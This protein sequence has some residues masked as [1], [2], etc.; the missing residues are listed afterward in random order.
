MNQRRRGPSDLDETTPFRVG[1][2]SIFPAEGR[3]DGPAGTEQVDPKVMAVMVELAAGAGSVVARDNLLE[4]VWKSS[5]VGDDVI[6]RCIYCLRGHLEAASGNPAY[7]EAIKTLPRRGYRLELK[8]IP[9]LEPV[10]EP[11][12]QEGS[13]AHSR[14][15]LLLAALL[16][17]VLLLW[18]RDPLSL[19][20]APALSTPAPS[21]AVLPFA[22]LSA[23]GTQRHL[24][25]GIA[26]GMISK[27]ASKLEIRIIARSSSFALGD[28]ALEADQIASRLGVTHFIEGSVLPDGERIRV[29][30]RL[31][32]AETAS[33]LWSGRWHIA[34]TDLDTV[35]ADLA[36][37]VAGE[38]ALDVRQSRTTPTRPESA[39]ALVDYLLADLLIHRRLSGDLEKALSML[40]KILNAEPAFA[41]GWATLASARWLSAMTAA[42]ENDDVSEEELASGIDAARRAAE[43]AISL[44]PQ[45]VEALL[46][47][48]NVSRIHGQ[49]DFA[50]E[51]FER[52]ALIDPT[53][54]TLL[55][56][57]GG[58]EGRAANLDEAVRLMDEALRTDPLAVAWRS[59]LAVYLQQ[60]GDLARAWSETE[61][62]LAITGNDPA[63]DLARSI[64]VRI[65]LAQ[66]RMDEALAEAAAI[67]SPVSRADARAVVLSARDEDASAA[68]DELR[69]TGTTAA[70]LA[71]AEVLTFRGE[72]DA[73]I[74]EVIDVAR[75]WQ[76]DTSPMRSR[77]LQN[78]IAWHHQLQPLEAHPDWP[79][80]L[81]MPG[82]VDAPLTGIPVRD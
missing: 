67:E 70:R 49:F 17:I 18:W 16:A 5:F 63:A 54:P 65:L 35:E 56:M 44:D 55:A 21:I 20:Q 41:H 38:L 14:P 11:G 60:A 9:I 76:V 22:D 32:E 15:P 39:E 69:A 71:L 40:E 34:I 81:G 26:D 2:V 25:E 51:L 64:R 12:A 10:D 8:A 3:I 50:A 31:V 74:R 79:E 47:L 23:G 72:H 37:A 4:R 82:G 30:A 29:S 6:S 75:R 80:Q 13:N 7:R 66:E 36:K 62:I 42:L 19:R 24:A 27:L 45:N 52:A 1:V 53:N 58:R 61:R 68:M 78:R 28:L 48:A 46:R 73:A 43:T 59:N 77:V 33:A 57:Q